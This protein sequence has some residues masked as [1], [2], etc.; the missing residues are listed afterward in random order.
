MYKSYLAAAQSNNILE[1][2]DMAFLMEFFGSLMGPGAFDPA[3]ASEQHH[4]LLNLVGSYHTALSQR[5]STFKAM[6]D[7]AIDSHDLNDYEYR[8]LGYILIDAAY[9]IYRG[10]NVLILTIMA[11]WMDNNSHY[12]ESADWDS[13]FISLFN[14]KEIAF[15]SHYTLASEVREALTGKA[16]S[17]GMVVSGR[18]MEHNRDLTTKVDDIMLQIDTLNFDIE[19]QNEYT[20]LCLLKYRINQLMLNQ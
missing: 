18:F 15:L 2:T 8:V 4:Q 14:A 11:E 10:Q 20:A 19:G 17:D 12:T 5:G 1:R 13:F 16:L 3:D 9:R 7:D 6:S